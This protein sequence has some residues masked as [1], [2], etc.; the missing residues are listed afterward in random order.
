MQNIDDADEFQFL[1]ELPLDK[2]NVK[3]LLEQH[4]YASSTQL[5]I[6]QQLLIRIIQCDNNDECTKLL[7]I[8][9]AFIHPHPML[10]TFYLSAIQESNCAKKLL[11]ETL[12]QILVSTNMSSSDEEEIEM[13]ISCFKELSSND[14]SLTPCIIGALHELPLNE[15][16][17][18]R[19][20]ACNRV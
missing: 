9:C 11:I 2:I 15:N 1:A 5:K 6:A 20:F 18:V 13:C 7:K 14:R 19:V 16:Q 17:L 4:Y 8:I 10:T 12:P 3:E